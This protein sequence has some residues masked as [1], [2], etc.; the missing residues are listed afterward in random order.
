MAAT[1]AASDAAATNITPHCVDTLF[2]DDEYLRP[3]CTALVNRYSQFEAALDR[4]RSSSGSIER[5]AESFTRM[6]FNVDPDGTIHYREWAPNATAAFLIGDFNDWNRSSH[7]MVR[8]PVG[9]WEI[10][11]PPTG[12]G[13]PVIPHGSKISMEVP[14]SNQRIERIPA[15]IRRAV[16][17]LSVSPVYE[18]IFWNPPK[19]YVF[20]HSRPSKP[21]GLRIYEAH[22]GISSPEPRVATYSE[23]TKNVI[24]RIK[25]LGY[26][27]IQLMAIMEHPYYASFGYQVTNFFAPTS[28]CGMYARSVCL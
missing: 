11:L 19:P 10:S 27:C 2:K 26:N 24:P 15:W 5:F 9:V 4:I 12:N 16:Q 14:G 3:Y 22:V 23:F 28:R 1:A 18:G 17:D 13:K 8:D 7:A 20:K 21:T 6:G 25:D